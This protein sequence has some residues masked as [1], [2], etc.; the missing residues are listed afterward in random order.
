MRKS[1]K[2]FFLL[3]LAV[4]IAGYA[5][6][7]AKKV[8]HAVKDLVNKKKLSRHDGE[9]LKVEIMAEIDKI[10]PKLK[11]VIRKVRPKVK[12]AVRKAK[13]KV[14]KAVKKARKAVKKKL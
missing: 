7:H 4:G 14:R 3:G 6:T 13:P 11:K 8:R 2:R 9:K 5:A 10:E 1:V 12:R